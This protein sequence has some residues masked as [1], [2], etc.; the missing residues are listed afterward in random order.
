MTPKKEIEQ[1][2]ANTFTNVTDT[3]ST[4]NDDRIATQTGTR[5]RLSFT[6][7]QAAPTTANDRQR[8]ALQHADEESCTKK[9]ASEPVTTAT[10]KAATEST[11][12]PRAKLPSPH[13]RFLFNPQPDVNG[14]SIPIWKQFEKY[15]EEGTKKVKIESE[16]KFQF[17]VK[18]I[19]D[20]LEKEL[21]GKMAR[22]DCCKPDAIFIYNT[23]A[24]VIDMKYWNGSSLGKFEFNKLYCDMMAV[25]RYEH[26]EYRGRK[27]RLTKVTGYLY[28]GKKTHVHKE[29]IGYGLKK[30]ITVKSE[31]EI[32][33]DQLAVLIDETLRTGTCM[34]K[35]LSNCTCML[36]ITDARS[37]L[38]PPVTPKSKEKRA[39]HSKDSEETPTQALPYKKRNGKAIAI[40]L[41]FKDEN[42]QEKANEE[43][44]TM[45]KEHS[46]D[47]EGYTE[48]KLPYHLETRVLFSPQV[49]HEHKG[50]QHDEQYEGKLGLFQNQEK[51]T[52]PFTPQSTSSAA[53][54]AEFKEYFKVGAMRAGISF[55]YKQM[56]EDRKPDAAVLIKRYGA[57][58]NMRN[59]EKRS[60]TKQEVNETIKDMLAF[61][62][63]KGCWR[64]D[65]YIYIRQYTQVKENAYD[66]ARQCN[67]EIVRE[68]E[69]DA[70]KLAKQ[71]Y[72]KLL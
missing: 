26:I 62:R 42:D 30:F 46:R 17:K 50:H 14:L 4:S 13:K 45:T 63:F 54:G 43:C 38:S 2:T 16:T 55:K 47:K 48:S 66:C 24:A 68:G 6:G 28:I 10:N 29:L 72:E 65:G 22:K 40:K 32:D 58:V 51:D 67:I 52:F 71:I 15:F 70:D 23:A 36:P 49:Q 69:I 56:Y 18:S 20:D 7:D 59:Y 64:V 39:I 3:P 1:C 25:G 27:V 61:E 37:K 9:H 31:R 12:I 35:E 33:A 34:L 19:E 41:D 57:I 8:Q 21:L 60:L 53:K 11:T 44:S 5:R